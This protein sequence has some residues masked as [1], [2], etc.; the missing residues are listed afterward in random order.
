MVKSEKWN[1]VQ[2]GKLVS[3]RFTPGQKLVSGLAS[4]AEANGITSAVIV[5]CIGSVTDL[6]LHNLGG[7]DAEGAFQFED[8]HLSEVMEIVSAEGHI[9]PTP[10]GGIRTHIHVVAAKPSGTVIG[11]HCEEATI[12]TGGYMFLQVLETE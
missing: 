5:S 10:D 11:G 1:A 12:C 6:R 4:F 9:V 8:H 2:P 7:I 3:Y